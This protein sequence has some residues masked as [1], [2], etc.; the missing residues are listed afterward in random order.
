MNVADIL[1]SGTPTRKLG[2]MAN[3]VQDV[4]H[5]GEEPLSVFL[6]RGVVRRSDAE[7]NHNVL[8]ADLAKYQ[9]VQPGDLV[10]NRLRTWQGGFGASGY[11]GIV[12]PAYIVL[13]PRD[14]DARFLQYVLLSRPYLAEL[15]RL[16]KWMPP[17]QFDILWADL[18]TIELPCPTLTEQRRIADFLDERVARIDRIV[19][20]RCTQA[21]SLSDTLQL[22]VDKSLGRMDD[23][24]RAS[25]VTGV[26]PGYAFESSAYSLDP[27]QTPLLRGINVG[28][29][30]LRWDDTAYWPNDR[31]SKVSRFQL[32]PGDVVI[33][34]DRPWIGAGLRIAQVPAER[35]PLLLQRVAKF[36]PRGEVLAGYLFWAYQE[37][38]F[39]HEIES[40]LT[41]L[42]VPHLSGE[43][44]LQHALAFGSLD[45]QR[46]TIRHLDRIQEQIQ[47]GRR[48]LSHSIELLAEYK[49]SLITAAVTGEF[50]VTTASTKI[51]EEHA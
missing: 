49:Q 38:A 18:K 33:G 42:S 8:G 31:L 13:R 46:R 7:G 15:T 28:V 43:Q 21:A 20:A 36:E 10:F 39:R 34:M 32:N 24:V 51:P 12:S 41:G 35:H 40:S 30:E 22:A 2:A 50:D 14:A 1:S 23:R 9:L 47:K 3:R 29:R 44:I 26:L 5:A 17:S 19:G 6:G 16:S 4:G 27:S 48:A 25:R 37:S 45:A 11:R